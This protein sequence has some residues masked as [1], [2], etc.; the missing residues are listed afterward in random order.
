MSKEQLSMMDLIIETHLDLDRQGPG[1]PE[2]TLKA[3]SFIENLND[4]AQVLDL[5]CGSGGQTMTLAQNI[6]GKIIGVDQ[7]SE[8]IDAFNENAKKYNCQDR[9]SGTVGSMES[10]P[11]SKGQFDLIWSEGAIDNIGFERGLSYWN[12][13][14]RKGGYVAVTCPSWFTTNHPSEV[15]KFWTD[16]GSRLDSIDYNISVMQRTGYIPVASF[17][18]P[19]SCWFQNYFAPRE[20]AEKQL[21]KKYS[22]N[23]TLEAFMGSNQYEVELFSKYSEYYGYVFY[24]GKKILDMNE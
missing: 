4:I 20:E 18:L 19:Q 5:G 11:F 8:F 16:A 9:V 3:L 10:L 1:S 15:E 7:F 22:G 6:S 24:I 2:V 12:G 23:K 13:F 17:I 21:L 14:L